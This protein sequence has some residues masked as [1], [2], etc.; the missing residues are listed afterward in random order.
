MADG[1]NEL[2]ASLAEHRSGDSG[3]ASIAAKPRPQPASRWTRVGS[4]ERVVLNF[5]GISAVYAVLS[6]NDAPGWL[7]IAAVVVAG[8]IWPCYRW[9]SGRRQPTRNGINQAMWK[10]R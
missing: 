1:I 5:A 3:V 6:L 10:D 9:I 7:Q 2:A 8:L 4:G